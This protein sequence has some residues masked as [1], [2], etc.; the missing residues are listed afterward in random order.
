M[1]SKHSSPLR[2]N[3]LV[4]VMHSCQFHRC[5]LWLYSMF[6]LHLCGVDI[7]CSDVTM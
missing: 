5:S 1:V 2:L 6:L 7:G 4:L 3:G